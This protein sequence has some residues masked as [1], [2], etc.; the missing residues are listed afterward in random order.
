MLN[1][2]LF[3]LVV[4]LMVLILFAVNLGKAPHYLWIPTSSHRIVLKIHEKRNVN[5]IEEY[6]TIHNQKSLY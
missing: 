3:F 4:V 2:E 6:K 5:Y 1:Q